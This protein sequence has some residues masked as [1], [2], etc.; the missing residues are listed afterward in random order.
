MLAVNQFTVIEG[1]INRRPDVVLFV[2]GLP[3][4][5]HRAQ[6]PADENATTKTAFH[7]LQ[8]YKQQI[9]ASSPTTSC[10]SP[11]TASRRATAP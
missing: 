9:P 4:A 10:S 6:E 3:L 7:Q 1:K 5:V 11:P 8:T 2:N